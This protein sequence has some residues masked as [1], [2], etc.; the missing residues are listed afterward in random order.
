MQKETAG[1]SWAT[2]ELTPQ[3]VHLVPFVVQCSRS[4]RTPSFYN[5]DSTVFTGKA[6]IGT[7]QTTSYTHIVS[8][9][10]VLH[11]S[12][13]CFRV[14]PFPTHYAQHWYLVNPP[15]ILQLLWIANSFQTVFRRW[16]HHHALQD[17]E[18]TKIYKRWRKRRLSILYAFQFSSC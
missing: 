15:N 9:R 8:K 4:E 11:F 3:F 10:D 13:V 17:F 1:G 12:T 6:G 5:G 14:D 2:N 7:I 18:W 16:T